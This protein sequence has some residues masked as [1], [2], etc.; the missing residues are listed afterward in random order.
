MTVITRTT[1]RQ[2]IAAYFGGT[3]QPDFRC[4]QDGPLL[5]AGL[6][7]VRAAWP[8]HLS[9][10]DFTAN[11][12]VGRAMGAFAIVEL[13]FDR[14]NRQAI[15]GPPVTVGGNIVSGGIKTDE[16]RASLQV[17]HMAQV[18]YAEDAQAD[19]DGL[20]EAMKQL[21]RQDRTLGGICTQAGESR[22]GIQVTEGRPS[23]DS[24]ERIGTWFQIQ[25]HVMTQ[26]IA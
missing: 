16:Y 12:P 3:Y 26:I 25:F 18:D 1:V 10:A 24:N 15:A 21:I 4:W 2:G 13:G 20:I 17:F 23:V 19:V 6:G 7:T 14:E 9:D 22:F 8:K 5:S 11:M